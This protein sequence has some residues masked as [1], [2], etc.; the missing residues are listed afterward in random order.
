MRNDVY[1]L[2]RLRAYGLTGKGLASIWQG[3]GKYM[4]SIWQAQP[5]LW[6]W[7]IL[8]NYCMTTCL[9]LG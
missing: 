1:R 6:T 5:R 9:I 7:Q 3:V 8:G 4:A 2:T